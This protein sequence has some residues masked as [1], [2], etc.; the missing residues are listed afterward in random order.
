MAFLVAKGAKTHCCAA[1]TKWLKTS[2]R[3][4]VDWQI[5]LPSRSGPPSEAYGFLNISKN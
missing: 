4:Q 1:D 3:S 5:A 2:G